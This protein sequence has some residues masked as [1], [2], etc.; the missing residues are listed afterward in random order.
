MLEEV[1]QIM[2]GLWYHV[3]MLAFYVDVIFLA[4]G[5]EC[6]TITC[7][8]KQ[9]NGYQQLKELLLGNFNIHV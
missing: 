7:I 2:L 9:K 5:C 1:E 6:L 3:N 8:R 4:I